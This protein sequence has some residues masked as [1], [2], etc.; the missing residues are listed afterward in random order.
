[1]ILTIIA[2]ALGIIS[3]IVAWKLNPRRVIYAELDNIYK[4]LEVCYAKRDKALS[5][6][7]N[8]SLSVAVND[9]CR[10]RSRKSTLSKR[11]GINT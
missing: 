3:T 10:L 8:N 7:D 4:Q 11:L 9:I 6:G 2:T 1:M 5:D